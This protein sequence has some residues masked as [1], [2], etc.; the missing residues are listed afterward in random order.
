MSAELAPQ[1]LWSF[2]RWEIPLVPTRNRTGNLAAQ[3]LVTTPTEARNFVSAFKSTFGHA[4]NVHVQANTAPVAAGAR[5]S[6]REDR[7]RVKY[8]PSS[9]NSTIF[10]FKRRTTNV[11]KTVRPSEGYGGRAHREGKLGIT[12]KQLQ[13]SFSHLSTN[14]LTSVPLL[15]SLLLHFLRNLH[16]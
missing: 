8:T 15:F 4:A 9:Q 11:N 6:G 10:I 14:L 13:Y 7:L 2:W 12:A 1:S 16:F 5:L 3:S